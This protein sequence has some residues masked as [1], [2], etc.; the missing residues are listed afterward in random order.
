VPTG[1]G[2]HANRD[3]TSR[4]P[5][6]PRR[7][8]AGAV[9]D[10]GERERLAATFDR[11]AAR[12]QRVRPEYPDAL[13]DHLIDVAR[14]TPGDRLLEVGAATGKATLPLAHRGFRITALEPGAAL[15]AAARANLAGLD[16]DVRV[17]RFEDWTLAGAPFDMVCA[18]TAWHWIDPTVRYRQA[19]AALRA[20]GH[21]AVWEAVHVF[22][23]GGDPFFAEI[24]DVYDEIGEALP[25]G[26]VLPRP[27]EL[28]DLRDDIEASELFDVVDVAQFD[29]ETI[30]DA[31][32]YIDLLST[33]SGHIAM[34]DHHRERLFGEIRR[35]LA[36]RADGRLRRHWGGVLHIARVRDGH[37]QG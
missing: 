15:A 27:Q 21:L 24:Q 25:A 20:G 36:T 7:R 26:S 17:V 22:P 18:A 10:D 28:P 23:Y 34:Q 6:G 35:R 19:A 29:W 32:G 5:P 12:Y 4:D 8:E 3:D 33:F 31:D 9:P 11:A 30:Y 1:H 2:Q 14:L 16:V 13:F 37:R